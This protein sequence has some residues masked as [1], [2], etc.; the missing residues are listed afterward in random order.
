MTRK[1]A[2]DAEDWDHRLAE[3]ALVIVTT[4]DFSGALLIHRGD[5]LCYAP[6]LTRWVQ[7]RRA[8]D[9]LDAFRAQGWRVQVNPTLR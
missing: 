3:A 4:P 5:V 8:A 6:G 9:A 1:R 2:E 7:G